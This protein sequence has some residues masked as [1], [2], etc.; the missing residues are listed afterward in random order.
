MHPQ[1]A[2]VN[3]VFVTWKMHYDPDAFCYVCG[4]VTL[5]AQKLYYNVH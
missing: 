5:K 1:D 4:E 2:L 3:K